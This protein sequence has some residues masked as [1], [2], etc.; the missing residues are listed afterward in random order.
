[1]NRFTAV[2]KQVF[3]CVAVIAIP[4]IHPA[5]K[6][7]IP[8]APAQK[9]A[10]TT[11]KDVFKDDYKKSKPADLADFSR[12]LLAQFDA[13]TETSAVKYVLLTECMALASKSGD[14]DTAL[15]AI[16]RL[17]RDFAVDEPALVRSALKIAE[18][19]TQDFENKKLIG[20]MKTLLDKPDDAAANLS[21]GL[22]RCLLRGNWDA[23]LANLAK[24]SDAA[25]KTLAEKELA[26]PAEP[27]AQAALGDAW[28]D[29][30]QK[31]NAKE[32]KQSALGRSRFWYERALPGCTGELKT[33]VDNR[34]EILKVVGP[35]F[36]KVYGPE[37]DAALFWLAGH[38]EKDGHWDT[39][40][41]GAGN[42]VDT[43]ITGFALLAFVRAGNSE[44]TGKYQN[45]VRSAVAWLKKTQ[46]ASGLIY[47]TTDAGAHRGIGYPHG[48]AGIALV[49]AA[50]AGKIPD[51][52]KA[53][54]RAVEY[55]TKTHQSPAGGFRYT[56]KSDGCVSV[57]GWYFQQMWAA[58]QAGL[59]IDHS[60]FDGVIRFLDSLSIKNA[61]GV[62]EYSYQPG[63]EANR[64]RDMIGA[65]ARLM[66]GFRRDD[67]A[68]TVEAAIKSGGL[69]AWGA[70]GESAD[71]YYWHYGTL[72]ASLIGGETARRWNNALNS[73]LTEHQIKAGDDAGSWPVAGE[74]SAEWG[75]IGQTAIACI[76]LIAA[77]R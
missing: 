36:P 30:A 64:R 54:Q 17:A 42:K 49:E 27:E 41:H 9:E 44:T 47:D 7:E 20:S 4:C 21:V 68:P 5:E 25:L 11:L 19:A 67:V 24:G 13:S 1:M 6:A 38:Q 18:P 31:E 29:F 73:A 34:I 50:G 55:S 72:A 69:P 39:V 10:L 16:D 77:T 3:I 52:L 62:T 32:R 51:T 40:K 14:I 76:A 74:F 46:Q 28:F 65:A 66:F 33:K 23:G 60:S 15:S 70:G 8:P 53:A 22:H 45:N 75:Q 35:A 63:K 2:M 59:S 26:K 43:A 58:K 61:D 56:A 71:L 57:S 37:V 48:I 12:K